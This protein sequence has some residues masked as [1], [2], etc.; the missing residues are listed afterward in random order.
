MSCCTFFGCQRAASRPPS[1]NARRRRRQCPGFTLVE[2]LVVI[3]IIGILISLLLPA[4][5][6]AREAARRIKCQNHLHQHAIAVHNYLD[7]LGQFP[8]SG[9]VN[10]AIADYDSRSGTMMSWLVLILPYTEQQPLHAQFDFNASVMAQP[11][12]DPQAAQ[13]ETLLCPSDSARG[14]FFQ[15]P[16][17]TRNRR[18]AKGNYAAFVSPYHVE[19]QRR[20][21]GVLTSHVRHTDANI[22][23]DGSSN[24]LM[25]SEVLTRE[26]PTDQR[27][28]WAVAWNGASLL[29]FD[30]HDQDG[31]GSYVP[32][33]AAAALDS[34]Q[35]P[36]NQGS[37]VDVLYECANPANAQVRRMPCLTWASTGAN[38]YL[39]SA[40]RSR[41]P[42]GVVAVY[43][44]GH[45]S[46]LTNSIDRLTMAYLISIGDGHAVAAQ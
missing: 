15:H 16:T 11:A 24:S 40:P 13:P 3:A 45:V 37:N 6:A 38:N 22:A 39:S 2:L 44:D 10:T 32:I 7:T 17:H 9:I 4:V 8:A 30:L 21:P 41:H 25:L 46:F 5:Q 36:N 42:G 26:E 33:T 29:A 28:A 12:S 23:Q 20:F 34:T 18:L 14:R 43:A 19:Y 31:S 35:P 27:G 1:G